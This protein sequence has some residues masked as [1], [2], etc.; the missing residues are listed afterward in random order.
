MEDVLK[1]REDV[2][3]WPGVCEGEQVFF[4]KDDNETKD[5]SWD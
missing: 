2:E 1:L 5:L 3:T 4:T